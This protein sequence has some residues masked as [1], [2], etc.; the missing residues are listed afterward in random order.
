MQRWQVRAFTSTVGEDTG[1]YAVAILLQPELPC[2]RVVT[3]PAL[4]IDAPIVALGHYCYPA[5]AA[6]RGRG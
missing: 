2:K 5:V 4:A 1:P 6:H 3:V